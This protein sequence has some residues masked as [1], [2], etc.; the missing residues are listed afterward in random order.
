MTHIL[1]TTTLLLSLFLAPTAVA[2]A[3][4]YVNGV[5]GSDSNNCASPTNACKTIRHAVSLAVSGDMIRIAAAIYKENFTVGKSLNISGS[6]A[7]TTII[8]GA[9]VRTVVTISNTTAHVTLS[10]LTIRNGKATSGAGINNSGTLTLTNSTVSGNL[11]PIPCLRF[12]VFCEISGGT[13]RGGGIYNSGTL[14]LSNSIISGNHAGSYCSA[15]PCSAFGG[16]IYNRGTLM[17]IKNSTLTGNSAST[18][19]STSISCAVGV[20]G[21]FYTSVGTGM[22]NN[23]TVTGNSAYR[24]SGTCGGRGGAIVDDFGNLALNNS[25]VSGN[26]AGGI[27]NGGTTTLQNTIVAN[28]SGKN[29]GGTITSHGYNLSSDG[30]CN[31]IHTGD[32]NNTD[33]M[34]GPLQYNGGPTQT[35]ALPLGSPAVDAGNPTGCTDGLGHLLKTDQ[36]GKP[37]PDAEDAT[38]CDMGAYEYQGVVQTGH[39]VYICGSVRCGELTGYCAGSVNGACRKTY[40]PGQCPVGKPAGGYGSFCGEGIDPTRT[41]TP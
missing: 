15:T 28:N 24:C 7:G 2:S 23:S 21:A 9:G 39:C 31:F 30:T 10:N 36:R 8:D 38:G 35:M 13:A 34:L 37:R 29:C 12:F 16:G 19:C 17:T 40:D 33:P 14:I 6:S 18:A 22:L 27:F 26:P 11:S 32:L 5:S 25:T 41:C 3:T 4:W 20:G 1:S